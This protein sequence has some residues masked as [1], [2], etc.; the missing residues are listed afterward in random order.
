[1]VEEQKRA[2]LSLK[3]FHKD[4]DSISKGFDLMKALPLNTVVFT[5]KFQCMNFMGHNQT[6]EITL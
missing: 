2:S 6:V 4:P 1:M 5:F 3:A